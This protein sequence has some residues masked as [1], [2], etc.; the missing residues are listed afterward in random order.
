MNVHDDTFKEKKYKQQVFDL[1]QLADREHHKIVTCL[2]NVNFV[3]CT[4]L[5]K[6]P[7]YISST[8]DERL[9]QSSHQT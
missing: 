6:N 4:G 3:T 2:P 1:A 7:S 5:T 9:P 8:R